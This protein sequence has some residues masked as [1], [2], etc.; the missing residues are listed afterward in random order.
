MKNNNIF[1]FFLLLTVVFKINVLPNET[2][3]IDKLSSI[4]E[5][6]QDIDSSEVREFLSLFSITCNDNIEFSEFRNE[7]LFE[8]LEKRPSFILSELLL[9]DSLTLKNLLH[10]IENPI[11]DEFSIE[12]IYC[13][14]KGIKLKNKQKNI[15]LKSLYIAIKKQNDKFDINCKI[16]KK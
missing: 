16:D 4:S 3:D 12:K 13:S 2:C 7:I 5:N 8:I 10:E 11:S 1:Q 9:C 15:I 14:I 6:I